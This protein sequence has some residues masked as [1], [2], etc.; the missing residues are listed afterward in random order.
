L[1]IFATYP[2][3]SILNKLKKM[4]YTISNLKTMKHIFTIILGCVAFPFFLQGQNISGIINK[5][6]AITAVDT[7]AGQINVNSTTG[8][9]VGDKVLLIQMSGAV[10]KQ[11]NGSEFGDITSLRTVGKHEINQIDSISGNIVFLR[12]K[13]LN[14]YF[15]TDGVCQMVSF[16]KYQTATVTDTIKAKPWDGASGGIIAFE[17][18]NLILNA[19]IV[20]SEVGFRGGAIKSYAD[21]A[22]G[23]FG[24]TQY[25][26]AL[27]SPNNDN[28][29]PK[30]EGIALSILGKECGRGAQANGG[31]GGNNHK[32]GG[33]GGG[34]ITDGGNGGDNDRA[35]ILRCIGTNPGK[36]GKGI[37]NVAN[38]QVFFG[39]GG[40]A[41]QNR[42][43]SDSKG[44]NGGGIILIKATSITGNNKKII[45]KGGSSQLSTG[46]GAGGAGAGGTILIESKQI[47]GVLTLE[48]TGGTGGNAVGSTNYDF[49]PGGGGAGGRIM[50]DASTSPTTVLTGGNAGINTGTNS[51]Q[52]GGRGNDGSLQK[53]TNLIISTAKDTINRS[54]AITT[55]PKAIS[56]CEGD[57][58]KLSIKSSGLNL[59]YQWQ[60]NTGSGFNN[61][62]EGS[63]YKGVATTNLAVIKANADLTPNT[64][65]CVVSS[66][67][68]VPR[69]VNSNA[70]SLVIKTLPI[71]N[72]TY[73]NNNN[74]VKFVNESTNADTYAWFFG[75]GKTDITANPT[76]TFAQQD[77]YRVVLKATN[78]CGTKEYST[79]V[80]LN[81]P[82][83][84]NFEASSPNGCTATPILFNNLSSDNVK[85]YY[86]SFPKGRP[87]TSEEKAPSVFY[88]SLGVYDVILVV[89]NGFGRDTFKRTG[90][91]KITGKPKANFTASADG[92]NVRFTNN[93]S[94]ATT[95]L[96]QYGDDK[97]SQEANP[98]HIYPT[99]GT[100]IVKLIATNSC[101]STTDTQR[102]ALYSLP[103]A[104]VSVNQTKGCS[105]LSVEFS[106]KNI[107]GV[108]GWSWSFPGG[109]PSV[110]TL[111]N[112]RVVYEQPGVYDVVLSITNASGT[113]SVKQDSFI[114]VLAAPKALFDFKVTQNVAEFLNRSINSDKFT[115]DFGDGTTSNERNPSPHTY[116]R[117]KNFIVSLLVQNTACASATQRQVPIFGLTPS[118]DIEQETAIKIY[119]N[120]TDGLLY[121]DFANVEKIDFQLVVTNIQGIALK[122]QQLTKETLQVVDMNDL[123]KGIYFLAFKNKAVNFVRKVIR[124]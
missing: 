25:Y 7:C 110:S 11:T 20:A 118:N 9:A 121:L 68:G 74:T 29:G 8:F 34:H 86:W 14:E 32:S 65:R 124:Y 61:L 119:P 42:E 77:T 123:P 91:I 115:W 79:V 30:G 48:S 98:T 99:G 67:C 81:A 2:F 87:A 107:V 78:A 70:I 10:I 111:P 44:S 54:F 37:V 52:N 56:I 100:Y 50:I 23:L 80:N 60:V 63:T 17:A 58:A 55:Q 117:N 27:N 26:Y 57:T 88:D 24:Y 116:Y 122:N 83:K 12:F 108:L 76:H 49:G 71:S 16:P 102:L 114:R 43:G 73:T 1:V 113:S 66:G 46:D 59:K 84:S 97:T 120:P 40:G 41:G 92:L 106:G 31:G 35:N 5:Y 62:T 53:I 75:N 38:D 90:Y 89:E 104:T 94:N 39:G 36:A 105:P 103:S 69:A 22:G 4:N 3:I 45:A 95:Y 82:P 96:W 47:T 112:P 21:C 18:T 19:P 33:G 101:G 64:Y 28:G 85:K 13:L 51:S 6:A 72:F 109:T 15:T 93:S